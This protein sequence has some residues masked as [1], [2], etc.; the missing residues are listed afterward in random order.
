MSRTF[1][2]IWLESFDTENP[3]SE[4]RRTIISGNVR[5]MVRANL[6]GSQALSIFREHNLGINTQDFYNI[7]NKAKTDIA[8]VDNI[9]HLPDDYEISASDIKIGNTDFG[10][11][12]SFIVGY[13]Y[14][15]PE[16]DIIG[17]RTTRLLTDEL[18]TIGNLKEGALEAILSGDSP[19]LFGQLI[20]YDLLRVQYNPFSEVY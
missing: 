7:W 10:T 1:W 9:S 11:N 12:Y 6:S 4:T 8:F 18:G 14:Y 5:D 13:K 2:D 19:L 17:Y 20:E 16:A 15:D 3:S